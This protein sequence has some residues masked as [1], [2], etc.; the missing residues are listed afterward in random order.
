MLKFLAIS[1]CASP[2]T[3][4]SA[5]GQGRADASADA[6]IITPWCLVSADS[7]SYATL[8]NYCGAQFAAA[9]SDAFAGGSY[10]YAVVTTWASNNGFYCSI[11][12]SADAFACAFC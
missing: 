2:H 9:F 5:S 8:Y 10:P 11:F 1:H 6:S 4:T 7:D 3:D 12:S